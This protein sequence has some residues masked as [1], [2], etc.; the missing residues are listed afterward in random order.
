MCQTGSIQLIL[1][2]QEI[3][4][5]FR[6]Q[7]THSVDEAEAIR[8]RQVA[9]LQDEISSFLQASRD[10]HAAALDVY[11]NTMLQQTRSVQCL[12][13][14][15]LGKGTVK[16]Y[17]FWW[18]G[19]IADQKTAITVA[20]EE[21]DHS[22]SKYEEELAVSHEK[23]LATIDEH[24]TKIVNSNTGAYYAHQAQQA[25]ALEDA[26]R[27]AKKKKRRHIFRSIV[28][29]AAGA[30]FAPIL[31][32]S[33][34]AGASAMSLVLAEGALF[35]AITAGITKANILEGMV[36]SALFASFGNAVG[37]VFEKYVT[38]IQQLRV[39]LQAAAI[40]S[41]QTVINGGKLIDN[42]LLS[43]GTTVLSHTL[44]P[45][46]KM[47]AGKILTPAEI[48]QYVKEAAARAF[49][50]SSAQAVL[51]GS[52]PSQSLVAGSLG[53]IQAFAQSF[54]SQH[55]NN[56][57]LQQ[58][59]DKIQ[60]QVLQEDFTQ[61]KLSVTTKNR[62]VE[63][64][65]FQELAQREPLLKSY[66]SK[67]VL[68]SS[69]P[70]VWETLQF[71]A[72]TG[73]GAVECAANMA[74]DM[75]EMLHNAENLIDNPKLIT[76]A[77]QAQKRQQGRAVLQAVTHPVKTV[78]SLAQS[79]TEHTIQ[80]M[81]SASQSLDQGDPFGAG[82]MIGKGTLELYY[83]VQGGTAFI[84]GSVNRVELVAIKARDFA[85]A[86]TFRSPI[87]FQYDLNRL[88]GGIPL[89]IVKIRKPWLKKDLLSDKGRLYPVPLLNHEVV[90]VEQWAVERIGLLQK[91]ERQ[92]LSI[93]NPDMKRLLRKTTIQLRDR[94]TPDDLAAIFKE[95]R[96]F[97][98]PK[99]E[100]G[101]FSHFENEWK[102][103]E[104]TF[105]NSFKGPW[106]GNLQESQLLNLR[107]GETSR[108]WD[109]FEKLMEQ[110]KCLPEKNILIP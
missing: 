107:F 89:D 71:A 37:T 24:Y 98:V 44:V 69:K 54:G 77:Y 103:V 17:G 13:L 22:I 47:P 14:Q 68:H 72:G 75:F 66:H 3:T 25:A 94:M 79:I 29:I 106:S 35:G 9:N 11:R 55:G 88:N 4:S 7:L 56:R 45:G 99:L 92:D 96:G 27:H 26:K 38:K 21:M 78:H 5:M 62:V 64:P 30:F 97:S 49:I 57:V 28:G 16:A 39:G 53:T 63:L 31:A 74:L 42:M 105:R 85:A 46:S 91:W 108:L 19:Q 109:R 33:F 51:T 101:S 8:I 83:S 110:A 80:G 86:Q 76:P 32:Q 23:K 20:Y 82:R 70:T 81:L 1:L 90:I 34:F 84:K 65:I 18:R 93:L 52:K 100:G 12:K 60:T 40:A 73:V 43:F 95:Q 67:R 102:Q 50:M 61:E 59:R 48:L 10:R 6:V 41:V 15:T 87:T 36:Q 2:F 104:K 58:L